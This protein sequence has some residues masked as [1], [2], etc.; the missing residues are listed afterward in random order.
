M[1]RTQ[2]LVQLSDDLLAQLDAR[3]AREG[4]SR[5]ELIRRAITEFL[6][7]DI[8]AEIDRRIVASYTRRPQ[9]DL[10]GAHAAGLA[11]IAAEPWD[12]PPIVDSGPS[13]GP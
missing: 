1:A 10:L 5:S 8:E 13:P 12:D 9:E 4:G 6:A 2:S 7:T 11:M 3:V